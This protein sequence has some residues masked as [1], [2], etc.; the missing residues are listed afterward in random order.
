MKN[1]TNTLKQKMV[2]KYTVSDSS[3]STSRSTDINV[4]LNR[5]KF[6]RIQEARKK[7]YFSAAASTGLILFGLVIFS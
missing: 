4:L 7:F 6:N 3:V 1:L 2:S 5:V